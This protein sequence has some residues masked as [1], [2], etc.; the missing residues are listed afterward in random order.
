MARC[1]ERAGSGVLTARRP[2][3]ILGACEFRETGCGS[4]EYQVPSVFLENRGASVGRE[5]CKQVSTRPNPGA[6]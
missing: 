3:G 4:Q 2:A 6:F 5:D 1:A